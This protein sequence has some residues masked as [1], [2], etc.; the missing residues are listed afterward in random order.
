MANKRIHYPVQQ[1]GLA[2]DGST[3]FTAIHGLQDCAIETNFN[4]VT[5]LEYGQLDVY[6][7]IEELPE[8]SITVSKVLDGYP[9]MYC[10]ATRDAATPTLAGRA[11]A[12]CSLALSI[13]PDTNDRSTGTP[14]SEVICSG[15][16]VN[17]VNYNFPLD[18][19][20]TEEITLVGN[21]KVWR[22]DSEMVTPVTTFYFTGA[23][24]NND[25]PIGTGG[26]NRRQDMLFGAGVPGSGTDI[27]GAQMDADITV[28]PINIFGVS[29]SGTIIPTGE[30]NTTHVSSITVSADF[31]REAI[32]EL[33]RRGP[34]HRS[35]SFPLDVTT[36]I[37]VTSVSGDMISATE[38]GI[39]TSGAAACNDAGNLSN[40]TIRI[41]TCEGTRIYMGVKN[42]LSSV[43]M[44]GGN[45]GGGNV[46]ASYTYTNQ[47]KLT[48]MHSGDPNANFAY[49]SRGTYVS[50]V[51]G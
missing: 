43:S 8:V 18:D 5:V 47:N 48:V 46:T 6:E 12:K 34:Y 45:T 11:N 19:N 9:L 36:E 24:T 13:F 22:N 42:K 28:L 32:N 1:V 15:L 50:P 27:N 10:L 39:L 31:N 23:F 3:T 7:N 33:G 37:Q 41:A 17:S 21:D 25:S 26:V 51:S 29:T 35:V 16:F 38:L 44:N 49:S 20:F 4:L 30:S 2:A 14:E 40:N